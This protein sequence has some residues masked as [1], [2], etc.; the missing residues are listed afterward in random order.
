MN[1][2]PSIFKY[3]ATQVRVIERDGEP[4]FVAKDVC[5]VLGYSHPPTAVRQHCKGSVVIHH[6]TSVSGG[7][8]RLTIIPERDVYRLIMRS[9]L[10]SAERFEEWVVGEVLPQIRKTGGYIPVNPEKSTP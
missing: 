10:P 5:T 4:W 7:N 9:K 2:V 6:S 1:N 3:E 8:P